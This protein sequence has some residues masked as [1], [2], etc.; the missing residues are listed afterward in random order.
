MS[1]GSIPWTAIDR[2]CEAEGVVDR[3]RFR[4]LI[5]ALDDEFLRD[6]QGEADA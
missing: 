4:R 1:I 3:E 2:Y 6:A 5:R